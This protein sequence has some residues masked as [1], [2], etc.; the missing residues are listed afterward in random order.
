MANYI[1]I[2][3]TST[4]GFAVAQ[5]LLSVGS[6]VLITG[7]D[8]NKTSQVAQDLNVPY[9]I[10]DATDFNWVNS[11]FELAKS[12][13]GSLYGVVNCAG[14]LLL[15]PAHL[16]NQKSYDQVISA[17]L[18]TAFAVTSAAGKHLTTEGG[19][20][21][22]V[23]SAAAIT[24][25]TNHEA[26]AAAKAGII[27]L[28][29]SAAATYAPYRL[30]FNAIAPGLVETSLTSK[31]TANPLSRKASESMHPLGRLGT[32]Q[33]IAAGILFFLNPDNDW[34]TGQILAIDGGLS[35][36]HPKMKI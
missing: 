32:P 21:V 34:V 29:F 31:L 22:L 8:Q 19:S 10:G 1:I 23:S 4:I 7:R 9:S 20:V 26:I 25:I 12:E 14:S 27:G 17:N 18:T 3:G 13:M 5:K 28:T 35:R 16:T 36:I 6:G 24:G 2:A 33:D 30:R 11:T 15:Q